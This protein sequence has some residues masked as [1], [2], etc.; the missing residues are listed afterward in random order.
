MK[1][2]RAKVHGDE[3]DFFVERLDAQSI[4]IIIDGKEQVLDVAKVGY[5]H[6]SVLDGQTSHDLRF[7]HDGKAWQA[8]LGGEHIYFELKDDKAI[9]R[10]NSS[11]G[12]K[13]ASG[14]ITAPMPGK[15]V[16]VKVVSGQVVKAGEGVIVV[17]AM[18]M[19]NEFK[20]AIDGVVKDV[21]V[22]EGD[23]VESGTVMIVIE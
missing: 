17:E 3:I 4:K 6:Y 7:H 5:H 8:F 10:E 11:G 12:L 15:V 22:S 23:S 2:F 16:R 19:E 20:A 14:T 18:K 21:K 13:E 1:R 9:R